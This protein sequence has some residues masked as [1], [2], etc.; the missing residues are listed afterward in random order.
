M[1]SWITIAT[2]ILL[3]VMTK[4]TDSFHNKLKTNPRYLNHHVNRRCDDLIE[5]LLKIEEDSFYECMRKEV[6][7]TPQD[8]SL[9]QE[10]NERHYRGKEIDDSAVAVSNIHSY[11]YIYNY[12][13]TEHHF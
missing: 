6:M 10:G 7:L 5:V 8:A 1:G 2:N 4:F 3:K 9:K 11:S 13:N 12:I